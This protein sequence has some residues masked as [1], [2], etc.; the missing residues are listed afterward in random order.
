M[1]NGF[2]GE[3]KIRAERVLGMSPVDL[4]DLLGVDFGDGA[5]DTTA[6][7]RRTIRYILTGEV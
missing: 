5:V 7:I 1:M 4:E 2:V 3:I 6:S